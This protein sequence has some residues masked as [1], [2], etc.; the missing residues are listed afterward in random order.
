[1]TNA[2]P[3]YMEFTEFPGGPEGPFID[4]IPLSES[5]RCTW[6]LNPYGGN[7]E[8][9]GEGWWR[10]GPFAWAND[11]THPS[12][13]TVGDVVYGLT[14]RPHRYWK[15]C[16]VC[17]GT[18]RVKIADHPELSTYCPVKNCTGGKVWLEDMGSYYEISYLTVGQVRVVVGYG[19]EVTYMCEE[20]G[21]GSGQVWHEGR[22]YPSYTAAEVAAREQGA[23]LRE[24]LLVPN[25]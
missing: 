5:N 19:A 25:V 21:V 3:F 6:E 17:N 12:R 20:T 1:M 14:V 13:Y 9:N 10:I 22:L 7:W 4:S 15:V 11:H 8:I 18:A 24:E 2:E 16:D 23:V